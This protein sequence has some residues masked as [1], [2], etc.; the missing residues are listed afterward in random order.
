MIR[1]LLRELTQKLLLMCYMF[2]DS[3]RRRMAFSC[4]RKLSA[5]LSRIASKQDADFYCLNFLHSFRAEN[6]FE[7]QKKYGKIKFSL[8]L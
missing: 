3:K 1:K 7:S 8:L 2:N 5:L 6:K 4:R